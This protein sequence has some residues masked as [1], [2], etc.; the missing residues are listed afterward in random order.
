MGNGCNIVGAVVIAESGCCGA[1]GV[2]AGEGNTACARAGIGGGSIALE[3]TAFESTFG[4]EEGSF[5]AASGKN[6]FNVDGLDLLSLTDPFNR[7][8]FMVP[9]GGSVCTEGSACISSSPAAA[10]LPFPPPT[11]VMSR[12]PL[13]SADCIGWA[14]GRTARLDAREIS[15]KVGTTG[16]DFVGS[17]C[18]CETVS[19]RPAWIIRVDVRASYHQP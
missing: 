16:V 15:V 1:L 4:A 19:R 3:S 11:P 2:V 14:R 17:L 9:C 7:T 12:G 6:C 13:G 18:R 5:S 8:F 10:N